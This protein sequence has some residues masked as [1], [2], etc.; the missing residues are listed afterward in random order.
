MINKV[1]TVQ[2]ALQGIEDGMT[3]MLGGLVYVEFRKC[4]CRISD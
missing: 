3:I 1:E 4:H 2:E